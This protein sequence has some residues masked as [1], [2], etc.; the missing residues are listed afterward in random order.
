MDYDQDAPN[1]GVNPKTGLGFRLA[2]TTT[3]SA[4]DALSGGTPDP[5]VPLAGG[6]EVLSEVSPDMLQFDG[7]DLLSDTS[8]WVLGSGTTSTTVTDLA[9]N[10]GPTT[11]TTYDAEGRV[12]ESRT[13]ASNGAD[14]GTTLSAYYGG[15]PNRT[16]ERMRSRPEWAGLAC[17]TWS[18]DASEPVTTTTYSRY[19]ARQR[20]PNPLQVPAERLPRLSM[21]P[22]EFS[23]VR[24]RPTDWLAPRAC[25][26][27]GRPTIRVQD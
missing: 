16:R 4:A 23:P 18:P 9:S 7:T 20:L 6:E 2:T 8:G 14:A 17:R 22:D 19:L 26:P 21:R 3:W 24:P 13:A 27:P 1:Q 15:C 5:A 11:L 25:Q 10:A 12:L